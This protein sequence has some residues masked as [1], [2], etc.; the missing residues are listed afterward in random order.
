[1]QVIN[2]NIEVVSMSNLES[3]FQIKWYRS[4]SKYLSVKNF[5][6]VHIHKRVSFHL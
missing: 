2:E 5:D 4:I 6:Y 1:M 3:T